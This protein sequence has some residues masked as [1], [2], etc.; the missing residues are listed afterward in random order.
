MSVMSTGTGALIAFQRA[1]QTVSHNVANT[2][3]DGYSRQRTSFA[4]NVPNQF[5]NYYVGNGT[6]VS[7]ISRVADQ[8]AISRLFD[9]TGEAARLKQLSD[10]SSRVDS[11]FSDKA[12]GIA[13]PLSNFFD[14]TSSLSSSAPTTANRQSLLDSGNA[15]VT[16]FKQL[17]G[18]I[19]SLNNEVNGGLVSGTTEANNL[20][21]EIAKINGQI[22]S[23]ATNAPPDLLDH[24]DQLISQLVSFTGGSVV[25]QDGGMMNVYTAGGQAM[26]VG[27]TASVLV[28]TQD[29]YQPQRLQI[30]LKTPGGSTPLSSQA[31]GGKI[32]GYL[33]FRSSV[34]DPTTAELGRI[35][36]GLASSYN[37]QHKAGMDLYGQMGGNF[38]NLPPP[39]VNG[40]SANTGNAAF[41]T[42]VSDVSKLDG[43]NLLLT[44]NGST[45]SA[46]RADTGASVAMTGSGTGADP[47]MVNGVS[48]QVSGTAA[49][50]DKFLVQPTA[51][52]INNLS[53]AITD[54]SR[55]AAATPIKATVSLNNQ[56]TGIVS[57]VQAVDATNANLLTPSNI[58]F[59]DATHYTIDGTGPFAYTAG[60][61]ISANGW[62]MTLD[63]KPSPGD[64]FAVSPTGPGSS[65]NGN[66]QLLSH[67]DNAKAFNGGTITLN[68][69]VAGLST[70]IGSAARQAQ[71]SSD[72]QNVIQSNAKDA[73]DSLSGVNLDEEAANMLQLQQAYEAASHIISTADTMF[74][75]I[76]SAIR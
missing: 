51:S 25:Q 20:A 2:N 72:A 58:A 63:G 16:R 41:T 48:L 47:F 17:N 44:Y 60:Q 34:L 26:V 67:L 49:A 70:T 5:G 73:R 9:S 38:F 4:T 62:S 21:T 27:T 75:S 50:G 66:A 33:E 76:L 39:T 11:V 65:D 8:L 40:N 1:L 36:T 18:Q 12:T 10:M 56:G 57:K 52:A 61:T 3:T 13:G 22:G 35:A 28:T 37:Q 19:D 6:H 71:Y 31:L 69:A 55:I 45:W 14:A 42:N 68:G 59:V 46:S 24:R 7:D 30:A 29:P 53:V 23:N 43:Q 64:S 15:L 74:Q 54:P 32:G